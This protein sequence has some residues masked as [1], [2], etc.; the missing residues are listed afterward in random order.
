[1]QI[2]DSFI[3]IL[4]ILRFISFNCVYVANSNIN[5]FTECTISFSSGTTC[6]YLQ[7]GDFYFFQGTMFVVLSTPIRRLILMKV[8]KCL[9][10]CHLI[11]EFWKS[12]IQQSW[13]YYRSKDNIQMIQK[14][15]LS[16]ILSSD[17]R[18]REFI[19][20]SLMTVMV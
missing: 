17:S 14:Q 1:M 5:V 9:I 20:V 8:E 15:V 12:F 3:I 19:F 18:P 13:Q 2:L 7:T 16:K 11:L 4:V 6:H 10:I